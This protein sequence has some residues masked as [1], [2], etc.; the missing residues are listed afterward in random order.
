MFSPEKNDVGAVM[1]RTGFVGGFTLEG[2][3][4]LRTRAS[5]AA[6][7]ATSTPVV[8]SM[9]MPIAVLRDL[10]QPRG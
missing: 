2:G 4:L 1:G 9:S 6:F 7:G 8:V 5:I 3:G 10:E